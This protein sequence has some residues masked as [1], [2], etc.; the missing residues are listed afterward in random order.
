MKAFIS[1]ILGYDPKQED[2]EGGILGVVKAY[3]GCI[4]AQGR[5]TLHCHT[6]IWLEGGLNPNQIKAEALQDG[7]YLAFQ[8]RLMDFLRICS[9]NRMSL[10]TEETVE[11]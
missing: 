7:G 1:T 4:E 6:L 10:I 5:G 11:I 9:A 2:I 8:K 3:Y